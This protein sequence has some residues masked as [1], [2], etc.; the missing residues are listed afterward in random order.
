MS[1]IFVSQIQSMLGKPFVIICILSCIVLSSCEENY[2][3]KPRGY[4]RI[5]FPDK[6][7]VPYDPVSC[8]YKFEAPEYANM[9]MD[10]IG[11]REYCWM[12]V[13]FPRYRAQL[14]I[15]YKTLDGDLE[16]YL[17]DSRSLVLKHIAK[18]DAINEIPISNSNGV[19]GV[20]YDIKGNAASSIQFV[21]T[22]STKHF[23]RAAL[24]FRCAPNKDSLAPVLDFLKPDIAHI[25]N[26][27]EWKN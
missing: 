7:Y 19:H 2:F 3:P 26:S 23:I 11:L 24:Y 27:M 14:H 21:A 12:D 8:P 1:Y 25:I 17:E 6:K 9:V 15:S 4:F 13:N 5:E 20:I 18:A 22:D 10:T 16:K